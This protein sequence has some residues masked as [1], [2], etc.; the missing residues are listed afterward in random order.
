MPP[1]VAAKPK[2]TRA[3]S[4]D[5]PVPPRKDSNRDLVEQIVVAL[6]LAFVIRGFEAE[7]FVIPTG[8]MAPTLMGRHKEVTCPQC[9]YV[10]SVN[11]SDEVEGPMARSRIIAGTCQNCRFQDGNLAETPSFKGDRI[12]VMKFLYDLPFLPGGGRPERWDVVVFKYPEEPEVN[13]IKRLVGMPG[14][15]LRIHHGNILTRPLDSEEPFR[16]RPR[17]LHHQQAMQMLVHDDTHR[18]AAFYDLPEWQRWKR[19]T[20][21]VEEAEPGRFAL[22]STAETPAS[23][24]YEHLVADPNQWTAILRGETPEPPRASL[25][26]DFYSYNTNVSALRGQDGY[27]WFEPHWVGDLTASFHLEAE[28]ATGQVVAELIEGGQSNQVVLDLESRTATLLHDGRPLGEAVPIRIEPGREVEI[29]FAN[30]DDR[31]TLWIDGAT[32]FGDGLSYSDGSGPYAGPTAADLRPVEIAARGG[33]KVRVSDL[34]LK[35][36]IYYTLDPGHTDVDLRN[37]PDDRP[38]YTA[39]DRIARKFD[40]LGDPE[41]F[42]VYSDLQPRDFP[43]RSGHFMMMGDNSPRSKDGRGWGT[44][45]QLDVYPGSGWDPRLRESWEVPESLL[46]GKAFFVYWPHAKPF[47][48]DIRLGQDFRIPFR[49]NVERMKLI[50]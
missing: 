27:S 42:A 30:V 8:S 44:A 49:P 15:E 14:E 45:D 46:I 38:V 11:A 29:T 18:P 16:L 19:D 12:L 2:S 10:Y 1:P 34:V 23:L 3:E 4:T 40:A 5:K 24:R 37:G 35:R 48:P 33:T 20:G 13:Y 36:D 26:T 31:L 22:N 47:G 39:A 7:A 41:R 32:P 25:I 9:G 21:A 17:P 43:I 6:I 50:R 28:A